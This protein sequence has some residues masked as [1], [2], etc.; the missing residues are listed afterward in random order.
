VVVGA[1]NR[2][3]ASS[4]PIYQ[5]VAVLTTAALVTA[6]GALN[7]AN[8]GNFGLWDLFI[9]AIAPVAVCSVVARYVAGWVWAR[10]GS[11]STPAT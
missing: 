8:S 7:L 10:A 3:G 2:R 9:W 4:R 6:F 1:A 5:W 11:A